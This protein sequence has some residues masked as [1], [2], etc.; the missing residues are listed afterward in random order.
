[1]PQKECGSNCRCSWRKQGSENMLGNLGN[2]VG[3]KMY[4]GTAVSLDN[5]SVLCNRAVA[6]Q[7]MIRNCCIH[8]A[9]L[10]HRTFGFPSHLMQCFLSLGGSYLEMSVKGGCIQLTY[11]FNSHDISVLN[12]AIKIYFECVCVCHVNSCLQVV[13]HLIK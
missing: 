3:K 5:F 6:R 12:L 9:G 2:K 10:K 11:I 4:L 1:M 7:Q 13:F 8:Q